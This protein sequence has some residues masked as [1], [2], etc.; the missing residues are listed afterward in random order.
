MARRFLDDIRADIQ[1][2]FANNTVGAITAADVRNVLTDIIDSTVQ[3]EGFLYTQTTSAAIPLTGTFQN[4][5][6][7]TEELGGDGEFVIPNL[8]SGN[9]ATG[10]HG[11]WS[12]DL[13][14]ELRVTAANNEVFEFTL[15]RNGVPYGYIASLEGNGA[16]ERSVSGSMPIIASVSTEV[17]TLMARAVDGAGNL[18]I[19]GGLL[20]VTV[21]PTNN[22]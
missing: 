9:I 3:D 1:T 8:S 18:V 10:A 16:D 14:F 4:I 19:E 11:G 12:Y 20:G 21:L 5:D 7:W 17:I 13:A 22:P 15:G 6:P 2:E